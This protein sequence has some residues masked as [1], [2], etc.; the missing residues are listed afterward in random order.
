MCSSQLQRSQGAWGRGRMWRTHTD[1][2][3]RE[4]GIN[5]VK[6]SKTICKDFG[7]YSKLE[8][9]GQKSDVFYVSKLPQMLYW[10]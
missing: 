8:G 2:E 10:E 7:F 3:E 6:S 1:G 4:L 5:P 9:F